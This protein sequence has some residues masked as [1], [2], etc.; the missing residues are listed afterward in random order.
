MEDSIYRRSRKNAAKSNPDLDDAYKAG[1][2]LLMDR[3]RL[4]KVE[5]GR[6]IPRPE[7]VVAMAKTYKA[8]E[9][10]SY[11]CAQECYV[12]KYMDY[13]NI[14]ELKFSEISTSL[15][16]SM[17]LFGKANDT[18]CGILKDNEISENEMEEFKKVLEMLDELSDYSD[19]LK[20]W[21]KQKGIFK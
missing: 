13:P 14:D 21:A 18:I 8:P 5:T 20:L 16:T 9:I 10:C 15:V 4:L 17:H 1:A 11:Y 12:G 2:A 7:E 3:T 19:A 6:I